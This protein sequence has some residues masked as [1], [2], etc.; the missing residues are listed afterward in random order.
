VIENQ[1]D[2]WLTEMVKRIGNK[3]IDE[4]VNDAYLW[5]ACHHKNWKRAY[6]LVTQQNARTDYIDAV[7]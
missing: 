1:R 6:E 3:T 7:F 5:T 2:H 4:C